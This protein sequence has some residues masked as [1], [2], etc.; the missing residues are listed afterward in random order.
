MLSTVILA[1]AKDLRT[2]FIKIAARIEHLQNPAGLEKR[3]ILKM[4][5]EAIY[6]YAPICQKLGLYELQAQ[7]EDNSLKVT[8]PQVFEKI[9]KLVGKTKAERET[10]VEEAIAGFSKIFEKSGKKAAVYGRAKSF[11]SIFEKTQRQGETFR[12]LR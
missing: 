6:I 2:I 11:Y 3:L 5:N 8:Q 9:R 10:E 1:T 7:L 12:K 4:S